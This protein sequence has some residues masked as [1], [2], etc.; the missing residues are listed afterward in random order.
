MDKQQKARDVRNDHMYHMYSIL[1]VRSHVPAIQLQNKGHS[2]GLD[3][4]SAELFLPSV[5]DMTQLKYSL[6]VLVGL[7]TQY[8]PAL[9]FLSSIVPS[10]FPT[11][12]H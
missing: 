11:N 7:L 12:T 9:L 6:T 10:I 1:A 8:I 5:Q 4:L 3:D 2:S